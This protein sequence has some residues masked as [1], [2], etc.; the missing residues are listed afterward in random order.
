MFEVPNIKFDV[1]VILQAVSGET[2]AIK[3]QEVLLQADCFDTTAPACTFST[4][5]NIF[6]S[7]PISSV[8]GKTQGNAKIDIEMK[9]QLANSGQPFMNTFYELSIDP[10]TVLATGNGKYAFGSLTTTP[11]VIPFKIQDFEVSTKNLIFDSSFTEISL[12]GSNFSAAVMTPLDESLVRRKIK[13]ATR[14]I[15]AKIFILGA[16]GN[17]SCN[18]NNPAL[19]VKAGLT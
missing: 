10:K 12:R 6:M 19:T 15:F 18:Y 14:N 17:L 8:S 2:P 13:L 4:L 3:Y 1:D 7:Q 16:T 9:L 5:R 11:V